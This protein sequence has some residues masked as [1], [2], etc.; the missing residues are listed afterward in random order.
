[1]HIADQKDSHYMLRAIELARLGQGSVS[2]NPVVGCVI[3]ENDEIVGEGWHRKFGEAHAE[4]NAVDAVHDK[5]RL[6]RS[7]VY[8]TLEPCSH[9]GKTP[10]CA[11]M[12]IREG[13][14]KVVVAVLDPNPLVAGKGMSKLKAAGI[15]I[16]TDVLADEARTMNRR[17]LTFFEK[18]R[19]HIILKWAE[20][21]DGFIARENYDSKWISD[22]Y[23]RQLVHKWR[24]EEDAILVGAN[25]VRY[26]DPQLN[27][28]QWTGRNPLRIVL[29][30]QLRLSDE[31]AIFRDGQPTLVY[32]TLKNSLNHHVE[33]VQVT[34]HDFIHH[35]VEDL[36]KRKVHSILVEGGSQILQ[37][38]ISA[39]LWDEARVFVSQARFENGIQAP[40]MQQHPDRI[41]DLQN[42][43]LKL[44][45]R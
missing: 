21:S 31:F 28:R 29:D 45:T 18:Q 6:K 26:D 15:E 16:I 25:T 34:E 24:S 20:T 7:T 33:F 19:P 9:F 30:R 32:N 27:V 42:D 37:A 17:F 35:V 3:V 22:E 11:D 41:E 12:L 2:P 1:M 38:F 44:Y 13:V 8:V 43:K 23:S 4:V 36:Y 14:K 10:P 40:N 39:G 5:S